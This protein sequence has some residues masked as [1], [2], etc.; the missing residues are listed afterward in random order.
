MSYIYFCFPLIEKDALLPS[1]TDVSGLQDFTQRENVCD[2]IVKES[3]DSRSLLC[4]TKSVTTL[5]FQH[6]CFLSI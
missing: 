1:E 6:M 5:D 3:A 2:P 4:K